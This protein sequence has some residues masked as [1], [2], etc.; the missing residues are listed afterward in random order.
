VCGG[1]GRAAWWLASRSDVAL[2]R[3]VAHA[4]GLDPA[5]TPDL[6]A[7][8]RHELVPPVA[9]VEP[10]PG[11]EGLVSPAWR[12]AVARASEA[13]GAGGRY[14]AQDVRAFRRN[15]G[16]IPHAVRRRLPGLLRREGRTA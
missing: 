8:A 10:L 15:L 16:R 7:L 14:A 13:V 2:D 1:E 11:L 9:L 6:R 5:K 4:A 12:A 3:V